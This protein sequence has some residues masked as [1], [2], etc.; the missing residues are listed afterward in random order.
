MLN[1]ILKEMNNMIRF[2][3][4]LVLISSF[5]CREGTNQNFNDGLK[6][7]ENLKVSF[8]AETESATLT[9]D[10]VEKATGY[11]VWS[12]YSETSNYTQVADIT[13]NEYIDNSIERSKRKFYKLKSYNSFES[14]IYSIPVY[15]DNNLEESKIPPHAMWIWS[16][17]S[18]LDKSK[19]GELLT[20]C[21]KHRIKILYF[22]TGRN[23]YT[24]NPTLL[25]NTKSFIREAHEKGI[26]VH[27]LTGD[28]SWIFPDNQHNYLDAVN[29]IIEY[30]N[31]VEDN[32][33][34]DGYQSD[35]EPNKHVGK[36]L[37]VEERIT[38]LRYFVDVHHK[39]ANLFQSKLKEKDNFKYG[40][41]ISA[42]YDSHGEEL[43]FDYDGQRKKT[44]WHLADFVDYFAIMSYRDNANQTIEISQT[45]V[46][47]MEKLGK[48]AWVGVETI[49]AESAGAGPASIS[50]YHK[51]YKIMQEEVKKM[52]THYSN[53]KAFGGIAIHHYDSYVSLINSNVSGE[54]RYGFDNFTDN[55]QFHNQDTATIKQYRVS[56]GSL[57]LKTRA[58]TFDRSKANLIATTLQAGKSSC[59]VFI[60]T[61]YANDQTSI[62]S[63]LYK[64]DTHELDF[65]I[66][67]GKAEARAKYNAKPNE[68]LCYMTS[69]A[70][71]HQ[72]EVIT[73]KM[74]SW[75]IIDM[76][77]T[78][79]NNKYFIEWS[80]D[81]DVKSQLQLNY[82]KEVSFIPILSVENLKFLGDHISKNDYEVKFD[83]LEITHY[84]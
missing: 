8:N 36:D 81:G 62:A 15:V 83:G 70:L 77:I 48:K 75:Y 43:V 68:V 45:E 61:M 3:L 26:E 72:S 66:G 19:R 74:D 35:I 50:F 14:S 9:W 40:M 10:I 64:D 59:R 82:G 17:E 27:G 51:G 1:L 60:P 22:Y 5:S 29:G 4:L 33:R 39:A 46:D 21:I 71:P 34:F 73:L 57:Y 41:A 52:E 31:S 53:N 55:W 63:F 23:T 30:N 47:L 18:G 54:T 44:L 24:N 16:Q 20:F 78:L 80:V 37:P 56:D 69:Q 13:N 79:K 49:D 11:T 58:Q 2:F 25:S 67:Y 42:F 76:D 38:N 84:K 32:E 12:S 6:Y 65:E 28:P 7:P